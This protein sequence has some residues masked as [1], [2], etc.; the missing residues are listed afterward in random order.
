M[1]KFE[2]LVAYHGLMWVWKLDAGT[3]REGL[4]NS[5]EL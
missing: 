5:T 1:L 3:S 4:S 2:G